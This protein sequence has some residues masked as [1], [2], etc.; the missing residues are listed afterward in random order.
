MSVDFVS[1]VS[2]LRNYPANHV[3]GQIHSCVSHDVWSKVF[4]NENVN[5]LF[6]LVEIWD[7]IFL[8]LRDELDDQ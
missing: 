6:D 7:N 4:G 1:S 2:Q 3:W 5:G 8:V